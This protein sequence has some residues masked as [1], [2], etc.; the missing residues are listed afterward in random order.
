MRILSLFATLA[1]VSGA[2]LTF[3]APVPRPKPKPKEVGP[4]QID[5]SPLP[6]A[7]GQVDYRLKL[8]MEFENVKGTTEAKF[9]IGAG[10][11]PD[12]IINLIQASLSTVDMEQTSANLLI[13]GYR[14]HRVL[15]LEVQVEGIPQ[16]HKPTVRR[17]P[18]EK[19]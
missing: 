9:K 19:K 11:D 2:M 14:G 3:A 4:M 17:L 18:D 10:T 12:S 16:K 5:F 8:T 7:A 15:R 1:L 13:K 6:G